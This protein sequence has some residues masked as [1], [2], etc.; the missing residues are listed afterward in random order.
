MKA[1]KFTEAQKAFIL[2]QGEGG[3]PVA[4]NPLTRAPAMC[5]TPAPQQARFLARLAERVDMGTQGFDVRLRVDRVGGL[6]REMLAGNV[7]EVA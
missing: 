6:A 1:S 7:G 3:T 5:R 4:E 2:K